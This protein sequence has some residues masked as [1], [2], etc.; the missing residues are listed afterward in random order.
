MGGIHTVY[1]SVCRVSCCQVCCAW[2]WWSFGWYMQVA[3]SVRSWSR[4]LFHRFC[5]CLHQTS[6][7]G[8][9][10]GPQY[11]GLEAEQVLES[12]T[13]R[14][15]QRGG[16]VSLPGGCGVKTT[17]DFF[18]I[19]LKFCSCEEWRAQGRHEYHL[20]YR[21]YAMYA[22]WTYP[23]WRIEKRTQLAASWED[24]YIALWST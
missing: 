2:F 14:L 11:A 23:F 7:H 12:C 6:E 21:R 16:V 13:V 19:S 17:I 4:A 1:C 22:T 15:S 24:S 3:E 10:L 5:G 9:S 18:C 20:I 8:C